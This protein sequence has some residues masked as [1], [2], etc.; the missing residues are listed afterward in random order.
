MT[1]IEFSKLSN[2][3]PKKFGTKF[4][5]WSFS[6]NSQTNMMVKADAGMIWYYYILSTIGVQVCVPMPLL[7]FC[8]FIC[9][10]DFHMLQALPNFTCYMLLE[11]LMYLGQNFNITGQVI[12]FLQSS[13]KLQI[14]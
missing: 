5:Y 4:G 14:D 7:I 1:S 10:V 8:V 9:V 11:L 12:F 13:P 3:S 2:Q 6:I